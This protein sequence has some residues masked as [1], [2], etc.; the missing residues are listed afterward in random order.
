[1]KR[2]PHAKSIFML[3]LTACLSISATA[4]NDSNRKRHFSP[5]EFHAKQQAFITEK[6][7][8]TEAEAEAFFPLFF[9]LQKKK[10]ELEHNA[11]KGMNRK[12]GEK[13]DEVQ[14]REFVNKMADVKIEIAKLEKE[15]INKYLQVISPC[16]LLEISH[17]EGQFQRYLMKEMIQ[18]RENRDK[19]NRK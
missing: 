4:Q 9:E 10:F 11:R 16:K 17:A 15:Y 7:G 19:Q 14:C 8:L 13:P 6:A 12:R 2:I 18:R 3:L 5:E 1:M